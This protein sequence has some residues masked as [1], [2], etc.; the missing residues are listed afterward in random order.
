MTRQEEPSQA[1]VL[2]ARF[3]RVPWRTVLA[4][5]IRERRGSGPT[6]LPDRLEG[7]VLGCLAAGGPSGGPRLLDVLEALLDGAPVVPR[8]EAT[9]DLLPLP[10]VLRGTDDGALIASVAGSGPGAG[11]NHLIPGALFALVAR[12]LLAGERRRGAALDRA[13]RALRATGEAAT[14]SGTDGLLPRDGFHGGW[15]AFA[16]SAGYKEAVERARDAAPDPGPAAVAGALAGLYWGSEAVPPGWRR[17][18]PDQRRVRVLVDRLVETDAPGWDGRPW[19]TS[20]SS[21]LRVDALDLSGLGIDGGSAGITFLP[22]RRYVGYHTGAHWRDLDADA[23]RLRDLGVGTLLLLVEDAELVRCRV[24]GIGEAMAAHGVELVRFP[25]PDPLLPRDAAAFRR[26][27]DGLLDRI[28]AGASIAIACRGGLD[29][30]GM[31]SACLLREA[32][33]D[34]GAAIERVQRARRGALT[35]PD[36][37]A[38]V[39]AWPPRR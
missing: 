2:R 18:L 30:A 15:A 6:V 9:A 26:T 22:G 28:R 25:I 10:L 7:A 32:G 38:F 33:L 3:S 13:A 5:S 17:T 23:E 8:A 14:P 31:T 19:R 21:P 4:A 12:R 27:V 16:G 1:D 24:A 20:T 36:Q 34:A 39:R 37:Q 29:R 11:T 35:L